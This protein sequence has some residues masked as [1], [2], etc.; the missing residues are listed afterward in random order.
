MKNPAYQESLCK[1]HH[2]HSCS[3]QNSYAH[4]DDDNDLSPM[5][6]TE[7]K[8][9]LSSSQYPTPSGCEPEFM[10]EVISTPP[11]PIEASIRGTHFLFLNV[12]GYIDL[13]PSMCEYY[14]TLF[15][16]FEKNCG[17]AFRAI[18]CKREHSAVMLPLRI[19]ES[20]LRKS[21]TQ[22]LSVADNFKN[23]KEREK[24]RKSPNVEEESQMR[25]SRADNFRSFG[26]ATF[27]RTRTP[28][29]TD[30]I[31]A[32]FEEGDNDGCVT[33]R[34]AMW[35]DEYFH[36]PIWDGDHIS[37][38]GWPTLSAFFAGHGSFCAQ[39]KKHF[40]Q[41][42]DLALEIAEQFPICGTSP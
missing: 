4:K 31:V 3:S 25:S 23:G 14:N 34:S 15:E 36:P 22:K 35:K 9:P 19:T 18:A 27:Q 37:S 42:K 20:L 30:P 40:A 39:R 10:E 33:V 5:L 28:C 21:D 32:G 41:W 1:Q 13:L 16:N 17:V 12:D 38:L 29:L 24:E 2:S 11:L 7:T 26:D 8:T 6:P